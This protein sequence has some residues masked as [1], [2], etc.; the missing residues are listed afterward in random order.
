MMY[1]DFID[2]C[3]YQLIMRCKEFSLALN[4]KL[5]ARKARFLHFAFIAKQSV[6]LTVNVQMT[7]ND[8][9]YAQIWSSLVLH[10][11]T[12]YNG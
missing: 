9:M 6:H 1:V 4:T 5:H 12:F 8:L 11:I 3:Q 2:T 10:D 7:W